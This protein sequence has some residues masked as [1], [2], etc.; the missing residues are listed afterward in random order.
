MQEELFSLAQQ[1]NTN[2]EYLLEAEKHVFTNNGG[3]M[4]MVNDMK[5]YLQKKKESM[6]PRD[7]VNMAGCMLL[8]SGEQA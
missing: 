8:L 2:V 6:D 5:T 4:K 3:Y 7:E 1:A